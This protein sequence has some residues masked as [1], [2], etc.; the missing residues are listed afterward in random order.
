MIDLN[1]IRNEMRIRE[2]LR[3]R[4]R[5]LVAL[6]DAHSKR[7]GGN[8]LAQLIANG[9]VRLKPDGTLQIFSDKLRS[10]QNGKSTKAV[11]S[12]TVPPSDYA[13]LTQANRTRRDPM[14]T[15]WIQFEQE[16]HRHI[17]RNKSP[18]VARVCA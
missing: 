13:R 4:D 8:Y 5:S 7:I 9:A 16:I 18:Q 2:E 6:I 14:T 15:R 17:A 12:P 3:R 10:R 1:E 11:A